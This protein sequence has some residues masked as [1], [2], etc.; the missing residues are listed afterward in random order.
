MAPEVYLRGR[1]YNA[2]CDVYSFAVLFWEMLSLDRPYSK[3]KDEKTF[4]THVIKGGRRPPL[5]RAWSRN[6]RT[7][8]QQA[9]EADV[10]KR[11]EMREINDALRRELILLGEGEDSDFDH[12]RRRSTFVFQRKSARSINN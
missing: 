3:Y 5:K 2:G 10:T 6:C 7:L 11:I 9:W 8:L 1:P 12:V 4:A